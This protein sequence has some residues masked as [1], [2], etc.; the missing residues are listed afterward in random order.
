MHAYETVCSEC[1][2]DLTCYERRSDDCIHAG[3]ELLYGVVMVIDE[4]IHQYYPSIPCSLV[5]LQLRGP[6]SCLKD[7]SN[8]G[9]I[10][11]RWQ[12][13]RPVQLPI[14]SRFEVVTDF[15]VHGKRTWYRTRIHKYQNNPASIGFI[16]GSYQMA[17]RLVLVG[18]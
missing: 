7:A 1:A 16:G 10:G 2:W 13:K 9:A 18:T 17:A 8:V 6:G 4:H 14:S 12:K 11:I 3:L 15:S 5:Y